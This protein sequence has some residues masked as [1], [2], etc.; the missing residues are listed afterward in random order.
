MQKVSPLIQSVGRIKWWVTCSLDE[1]G[2]EVKKYSSIAEVPVLNPQMGCGQEI[3][4]WIFNTNT[5]LRTFPLWVDPTSIVRCFKDTPV[6]I[7]FVWMIQELLE[8]LSGKELILF[9]RFWS[10]K[11]VKFVQYMS[12]FVFND[13]G[14][15]YAP[16]SIWKW[17]HMH[18]FQCNVLNATCI[19]VHLCIS[20]YW[21]QNNSTISR[22]TFK[23]EKIKCPTASI[24]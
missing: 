1:N 9:F 21:W 16:V 20:K 5:Y 13:N 3:M 24:A 8:R 15:R 11:F 10:V 17:I 12:C 19:L 23:T 22:Y 18:N 4:R 2:H 6:I 14:I 7:H